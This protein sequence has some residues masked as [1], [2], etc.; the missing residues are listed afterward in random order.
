VKHKCFLFSKKKERKE[1]MLPRQLRG[2]IFRPLQTM[3]VLLSALLT[4]LGKILMSFR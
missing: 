2:D 1:R 4:I 3:F